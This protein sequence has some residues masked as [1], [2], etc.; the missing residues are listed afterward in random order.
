MTFKRLSPVT[1]KL[2]TSNTNHALRINGIT[3]ICVKEW[4]YL[5][6]GNKDILDSVEPEKDL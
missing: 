2:H 6:S 5:K 3:C 4:F 1:A